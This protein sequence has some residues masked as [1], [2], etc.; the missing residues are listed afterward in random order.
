MSR[1]SVNSP[2]EDITQMILTQAHEYVTS[3]DGYNRHD[4]QLV[5]SEELEILEALR[6]NTRLNDRIQELRAKLYGERVQYDV[7]MRLSYRLDP[8]NNSYVVEW[9]GNKAIG[10]TLF[11]RPEAQITNRNAW[12]MAE[13]ELERHGHWVMVVPDS[14]RRLSKYMAL[15]DVPEVHAILQQ[16]FGGE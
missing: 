8:M 12:K 14:G 10:N 11:A 13:R 5:A 9:V 1:G 15:P 6:T 16:M 7:P 2:A 4:E 3:D